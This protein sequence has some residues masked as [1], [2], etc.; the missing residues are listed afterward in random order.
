MSEHKARER[1]LFALIAGYALLA[2]AFVGSFSH[3]VA[4]VVK[5]GQTGWISYAIAAMPEITVIIGMRRVLAGT[6]NTLTWIFLVTAGAFTLAGNLA[7]AQH[8]VGGFI[9]AG[10]PAW[11]A[12]GAL[13]FAEIHSGSKVKAESTTRTGVQLKI[14]RETVTPGP[15]EV[16]A[17]TPVPTLAPRVKAEVMTPTLTPKHEVT[18]AKPKVEATEVRAIEV[19]AIESRATR[20]AEGQ[21]LAQQ[22]QVA[23]A[24]LESWAPGDPLTREVKARVIELTGVSET[25][26][27]RAAKTLTLK[28]DI[29]TESTP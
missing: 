2:A 26:V 4:S 10:W 7:S 23:L 25:T 6:M 14:A 24:L 18:R 3:V 22:D 8:S 20:S 28:I 29:G 19:R 21:T 13:V 27:K 5:W 17:P 16:M 15:A 11:S 9:A 1:D 12:V